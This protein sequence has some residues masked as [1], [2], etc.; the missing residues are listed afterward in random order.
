MD[1][2]RT[3]R[4]RHSLAGGVEARKGD[5]EDLVLLLGASRKGTYMIH[6]PKKLLQWIHL[7]STNDLFEQLKFSLA[8][9][10]LP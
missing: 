7:D 3:Q 10:M 2:I 1:G 9:C 4:R 8:E 5:G 6:E